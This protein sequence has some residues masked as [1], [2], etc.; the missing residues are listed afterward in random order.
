MLDSPIDNSPAPPDEAEQLNSGLALASLIIG[1]AGIV[2]CLLPAGIVAVILGIIAL[3]LASKE[4]Q[5]YGGHGMALGGI[6]IGGLGILAILVLD[7]EPKPGAVDSAN[8]HAIGQGIHMYAETNGGAHPPDLNTLVGLG[9]CTPE[10]LI[11]PSSGSV[12]PTCDYYY[13]ANSRHRE[14]PRWFVAYCDPAY[15]DGEGATVLSA[16]GHTLFIQEPDFTKQ[17]EE[18]F[19]DFE[20]HRGVP[21][22]VIPPK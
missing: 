9:L 4:P 21:P 20:E 5:R 15:H 14:D 10:D 22:V 6:M 13:V 1:I 18:F 7:R 11:H 3:V 16:D 19:A 12:P 8:L 2:T 17:L